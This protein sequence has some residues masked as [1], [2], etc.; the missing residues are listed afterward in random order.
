MYIYMDDN[1]LNYLQ[2]IAVLKN[3]SYYGMQINGW[4]GGGFYASSDTK[5]LEIFKNI[6]AMEAYAQ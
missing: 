3:R 2:K 6:L 1:G 5:A 4:Y